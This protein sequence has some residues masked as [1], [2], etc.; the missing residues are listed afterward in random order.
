M[1]QTGG[2][3]V[4]TK[5][6]YVKD[7]CRAASIPY[8]KAVSICVPAD[9]LI[10]HEEDLHGDFPKH[11]RDTRYFRLIHRLQVCA[12][13]LPGGFSL[14]QG[15]AEEFAAHIRECYGSDITPEEVHSFTERAVYCQ[16]LWLAV[17]DQATGALVATGIGEWDR[18]MGEGILEWIQVSPGYRRRGLGSFLVKELLWR[19]QGKVKFA[20]VS[21]QCDSPSCPE[22][23]YRS[24]GFTGRDVWH[25]LHKIP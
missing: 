13:A 8:W 17:R 15:T 1:I 3:F 19:M 18:Q 7:P 6:E 12:T 20:T 25:V 23:L 4:L 11:Y 21:G 9:M 22:R 24:C 2:V 10:L 16:D 5:E 14:G